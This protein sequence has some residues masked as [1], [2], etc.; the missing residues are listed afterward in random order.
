M[1][2]SQRGD[3]TSDASAAALLHALL[4]GLLLLISP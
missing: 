2:G 3:I 4:L 1:A